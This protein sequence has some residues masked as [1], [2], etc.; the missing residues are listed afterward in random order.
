MRRLL[1]LNA[2]RAFETVARTGTLTQA[3]EELLVTPTA[4]GRHIKNLEDILGI[5]L[6]E[7]EGGL[8]ILTAQGRQYAR[9][10]GRAFEL[11]ADATDLLVGSKTR[12]PIT[13]RAYTTF[14]VRWLIPKLPDFQRVH[15]EVELRLTAAFDVVDFARDAV[16]LGM[17]YGDGQWPGLHATPLFSDELV[18]V[19]N[20]GL[21]DRF[22]SLSAEEAF[23]TSTLLVHTL[24]LDDWPDW[25]EVAGLDDIIPTHQMPLDDMS[26]I[27]QGML[28][29]I[30][31]GLTQRC[32]VEQ[33]LRE[34]RLHLLSPN[35]LRR[36]RG[37]HLVCLPETARIPAVQAFLSW[38]ANRD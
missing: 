13:L 23:A 38:L 32:Y 28:D 25:F 35:V 10:L 1:P 17:R 6:F 5:T 9:S 36:Q 19:G 22:A 7:R 27:Y 8:L 24:R 3:G 11:I 37:F 29:G 21:R 34:G 33:D 2:L 30:G 15:P 12:T 26:L 20:A 18:V 14:L 16:D 4:V 31:V